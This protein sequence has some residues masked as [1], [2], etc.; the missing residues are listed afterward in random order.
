MNW[1]AVE[2]RTTIWKTSLQTII[3]EYV[4]GEKSEDDD[5]DDNGIEATEMISNE[6]ESPTEISHRE[7]LSILDQLPHATG[8]SETDCNVLVNIK[9]KVENLASTH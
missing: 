9:V 6:E 1:A 2:T 8:I 3:D 7:A 4:C 5:K